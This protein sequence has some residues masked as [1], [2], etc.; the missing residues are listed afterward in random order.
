MRISG[1]YP[2]LRELATAVSKDLGSQEY[3][4][5]TDTQLFENCK[6]KLVRGIKS[7]THK[8]SYD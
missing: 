6:E 3:W 4:Q 1:Y 7:C 8:R 5:E 2:K